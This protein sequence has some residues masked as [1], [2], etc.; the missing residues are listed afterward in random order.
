MLGPIVALDHRGG[1]PQDHGRTGELG[2]LEGHLAEMIGW[3]GLILLV[4][5]L[6]LLIDHDQAES[7]E[8]GEDRGPDADHDPCFSGGQPSPLA[9]Q[10]SG[11]QAGVIDG[12]LLSEMVTE[13]GHKLG[14]ERDLREPR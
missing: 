12:D 1:A 9:G 2:P 14:G 4:G 8:W 3:R 10:L 6:V 11:G 7:L 5:R 13:S